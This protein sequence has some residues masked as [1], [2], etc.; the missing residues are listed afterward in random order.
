MFNYSLLII[1]IKLLVLSTSF[2][3]LSEAKC[4]RHR[5]RHNNYRCGCE[6]REEESTNT[7]E[8]NILSSV[9]GPSSPVSTLVVPVSSTVQSLSTVRSSSI[10]STIEKTN[11]SYSSSVLVLSTTTAIPSTIVSTSKHTTVPSCASN[12]DPANTILEEST[13]NPRGTCTLFSAS[14]LGDDCKQNY[15]KVCDANCVVINLDGDFK[16]D[17][18]S[19]LT[20]RGCYKGCNPALTVPIEALND[21]SEIAYRCSQV[22]N[23]GN[24]Y[25][26]TDTAN[27]NC[28]T[29]CQK[30][31]HV[32]NRTLCDPPVH[33]PLFC[34]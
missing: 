14:G 18:S 7:T 23:A 12:S 19:D 31:C 26:T 16:N 29:R 33:V 6:T 2:D 22:C 11:Q 1:F 30:F 17:C 21:G 27:D 13:P 3:V 4:H 8:N 32:P 34:A 28:Y 24:L 15:K 25:C 9:S 5:R 10:L 20:G